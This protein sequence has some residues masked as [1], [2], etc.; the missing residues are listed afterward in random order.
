MKHL[1][2]VPCA[3][4]ASVV[5]GFKVGSEVALSAASVGC[6]VTAELPAFLQWVPV[7]QITQW[8]DLPAV[9]PIMYNQTMR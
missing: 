9:V 1:S 7:Y 4:H 5:S 3:L 2:Y 8:S 6:P